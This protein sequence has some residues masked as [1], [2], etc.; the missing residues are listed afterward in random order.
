MIEKKNRILLFVEKAM[1]YMLLIGI[2]IVMVLPFVWMISTSL[3]SP[4]NIMSYPP[5][6][7]PNPVVW[8][9]YAKAWKAAPFAWYFLNSFT[10]AFFVVGGSVFFS[11]L[12]GFGF[13]KYDFPGRNIFF[14]LVLSTLMVPFQM[15]MIPLYMIMVKLRWVDDLKALIVPFLASA[16]G[17]FLMRQF[18]GTIPDDLIDA[19]RIDGCSEIRIFWSIILP[20]CKTGL[21]VLALFMFMGSWNSFLW[22]LIVIDST[23]KKTLPLG[24]AA[25]E[26]PNETI[27]YGPLMAA[28][29]FVVAPIMILFVF[30]QKYMTK[31]IILTGLKG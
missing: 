4:P 8:G 13:A 28:S 2:A 30:T 21:A 15:T 20:L 10:V 19:A 1:G 31:G 5:K 24:L 17:T 7:I 12:A 29:V 14:I 18:I 16:F 25:F 3:K 9:N 11:T 27:A 6:F 23:L 26:L 22:P